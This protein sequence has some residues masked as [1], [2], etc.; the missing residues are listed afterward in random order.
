MFFIA[1]FNVPK[2]SV[3]VPKSWILDIDSHWEKFVNK[4]INRNQKFLCFYSTESGA[5]DADG[6]PNVEF[7]PDFTL[8]QN[9]T[10]PTKGCYT[11]NLNFYK[12]W[13]PFFSPLHRNL[14]VL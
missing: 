1:Y 14:F 11:V 2:V 10:F 7:A 8:P 13:Y 3:I 12:G 9:P 5:I 4:S 6:K